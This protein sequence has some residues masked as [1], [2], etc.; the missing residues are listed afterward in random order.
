MKKDSL[1][2]YLLI[3]S[4]VTLAYVKTLIVIIIGRECDSSAECELKQR[5]PYQSEL[6]EIIVRIAIATKEK[7]DS[8]Q[9]NKPSRSIDR[10]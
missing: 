4:Y 3:S 6:S 2:R 9:S 5:G 1:T 10:S 7:R 8:P